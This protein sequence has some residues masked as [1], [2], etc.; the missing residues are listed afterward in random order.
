M[1]KRMD[2][3]TV[4]F[5]WNRARAFLVSAEEGSYSAASRALGLTQPTV[6][7]QVAALERELGVALFERVGNLLEP[8]AA[9]LELLEHARAMG[10]AATGLS[11]AAAGRSAAVDGVVRVTASQLISAYLLGPVVERLRREHPGITLDLV[12]SNDVRD[13]RRREADIAIRNRAPAH[14]ELIGR[15]LPDSTARPY[16]TPAYLASLGDP[17]TP[18]LLAERGA[19][20]GFDDPERMVEVLRAIGLPVTVASFP[21]VTADHLVQWTLAR[22]GH[23]VC[24]AMTEV[25]DPDPD[26]VPALPALPGLPIPMWVVA[27]R[28]VRTS[29][30][31]RIVFDAIV[32]ALGG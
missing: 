23:G 10:V 11:L 15:R 32:Q 13:L 12:A 18:E 14:A 16:A 20:F 1:R 21:L 17:L 24:I 25:G 5:D 4:T 19:F 9:G 30:R 28:E 26:M 8:T 3:R 29:R 2:W 7:R 22:R 31:I 6:G 27:H